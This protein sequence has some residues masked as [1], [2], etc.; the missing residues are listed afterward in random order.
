M[1]IVKEG[2]EIGRIDTS[3]N[4]FSS[5]AGKLMVV[6]FEGEEISELQLR[7]LF[8]TAEIEILE[9]VDGTGCYEKVQSCLISKWE[10]FV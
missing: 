3:S 5:N 8:G 6:F 2:R 4:A 7:A 9:K 1:K 10:L